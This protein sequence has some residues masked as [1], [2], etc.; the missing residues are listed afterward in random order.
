MSS[1]FNEAGEPIMS[2]AEYRL[3]QELDQQQ[4]AEAVEAD[5]WEAEA[6]GEH[7]P[8]E[9]EE[10]DDREEEGGAWDYSTDSPRVGEG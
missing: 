3:E 1:P 6:R 9:E 10:E 8:W 2:A 4:M 5:W 7:E